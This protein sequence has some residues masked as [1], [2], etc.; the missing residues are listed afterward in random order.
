[1]LMWYEGNPE[2]LPDVEKKLSSLGPPP[3]AAQP[4]QI[5]AWASKRNQLRLRDAWESGLNECAR[6]IA[7]ASLRRE[8]AEASAEFIAKIRASEYA[9][10]PGL[11]SGTPGTEQFRSRY[12]ER[13]EREALRQIARQRQALKAQRD[14][15]KQRRKGK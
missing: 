12:L 5:L 4:A 11:D 6:A 15:G 8:N 7:A 3:Q 10:A 14:K 2:R 9:S 13:L 1:M